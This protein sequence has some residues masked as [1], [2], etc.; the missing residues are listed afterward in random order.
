[1]HQTTV[2]VRYPSWRDLPNTECLKHWSE[3]HKWSSGFLHHVLPINRDMPISIGSLMSVPEAESMPGLVSN[4]V[5]FC[6]LGANYDVLMSSVSA[7][8]FCETTVSFFENISDCVTAL[9]KQLWKFGFSD[10]LDFF[11]IFRFWRILDVLNFRELCY[12]D[13]LS[14]R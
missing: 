14:F 4:Y 10:F 7:N 9:E 5:F 6:T 2:I 11:S 12:S 8:V 1:M 3:R 13:F